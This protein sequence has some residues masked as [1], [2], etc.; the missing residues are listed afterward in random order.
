MKILPLS[1]TNS[2]KFKMNISRNKSYDYLNSLNSSSDLKNQQYPRE[3][4]K[5]EFGANKKPDISDKSGAK[6]FSSKNNA[7]KILNKF[8]KNEILLN[9]KIAINQEQI[10]D[11][12][13]SAENDATGCR[14]INPKEFGKGDVVFSADKAF[15]K[16]EM[17]FTDGRKTDGFSALG[18]PMIIREA[19]ALG[20]NTARYKH[21]K[22]YANYSH[23]AADIT[24]FD[25]DK[26]GKINGAT[27]YRNVRFD[28]NLIPY[29]DIE[30]G[31]NI[32]WEYI[33]MFSYM[34]LTADEVYKVKDGKPVSYMTDYAI[35]SIDPLFWSH[36]YNMSANEVIK[37]TDDGNAVVYTGYSKP[38]YGPVGYKTKEVAEYN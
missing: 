28:N 25:K 33:L 32:D 5:I 34:R 22:E 17:S 6:F 20:P 9:M 35:T 15:I 7:R 4:G 37:F 10:E 36:G 16:D 2:I 18:A 8:K 38:M 13:R 23:K 1:N 24:V 27:I 3:E 21:K 11:Y 19:E 29:K 12:L 14:Y 26:D 30:N 31:V